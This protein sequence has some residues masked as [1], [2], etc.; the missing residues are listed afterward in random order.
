MKLVEKELRDLT[1]ENEMLRQAFGKVSCSQRRS[2]TLGPAGA[3]MNVSVC[4][5]FSRSAT[6]C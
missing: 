6:S 4:G 2:V 3:L 5:R 1:V